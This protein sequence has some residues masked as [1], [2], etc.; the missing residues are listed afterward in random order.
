M[1]KGYWQSSFNDA[2]KNQISGESA[3]MSLQFLLKFL[4]ILA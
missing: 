3:V 2:A 4:D 1:Y